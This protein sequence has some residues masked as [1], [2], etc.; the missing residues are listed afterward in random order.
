VLRRT[1]QTC[2]P[3]EILST[4]SARA[5]D[6]VA[7]PPESRPGRLVIVRISGFPDGILDRLQTLAF[8]ADEWYAELPERGRFRLVPGTADDGLLL[9]VPSE[10]SA[11]PRFTFGPAITSLTV[12]AGRYGDASDAPLTFE[13]FSVPMQGGP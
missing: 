12:S 2:G 7:V 9:E 8:R 13:F 5:G 4:A 10:V 3:P 1:T 11:H 6:A